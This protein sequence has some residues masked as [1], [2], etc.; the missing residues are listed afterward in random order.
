MTKEVR[1]W[2]RY[3]ETQASPSSSS[4][5]GKSLSHRTTQGS[6]QNRG[7]RS[8]KCVVQ[9]LLPLT[10]GET[11]ASHGLSLRLSEEDEVSREETQKVLHPAHLPPAARLDTPGWGNSVTR[12]SPSGEW[13]DNVTGGTGTGAGTSWVAV[14]SRTMAGKA[15]GERLT[16]TGLGTLAGGRRVPVPGT[17][18]RHFPWSTIFFPGPAPGVGGGGALLT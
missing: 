18:S 15:V 7:S 4:P 9:I 17:G 8:R 2:R 11:S 13:Q 3:E 14:L 5:L 16:V 6:G 10:C 1:G 12:C